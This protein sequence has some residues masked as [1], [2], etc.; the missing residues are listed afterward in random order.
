MSEPTGA[1]P[2]RS[3]G[4]RSDL[5]E[6]ERRNRT[7]VDLARD[8][9]RLNLS[10][11][12][13]GV[14]RCTRDVLGVELC[15]VLELLVDGES[16]LLRA[17]VGRDDDL[18]GQT[19]FG[20]ALEL[21]TGHA[22]ISRDPVVI[23]DARHRAHF[24]WTAPLRDHD[25]VSGVSTPIYANGNIF[26]IL[27][28]YS[29][30]RRCYT[31]VEVGFL[32]NVA[33]LLGMAIE[34]ALSE[35]SY[36]HALEKEKRR[37]DAAEQRYALLHEANVVLTTVPNGSAALVAVA[38]LAVPAL[39]DWCFVEL[40][41]EDGTPRATIRRLV[42]AH[43]RRG[44]AEERLARELSRH[45]PLDPNAPYGTPKVLRTGR[46]ELIPE[47]REELLQELSRDEYLRWMRDLAPGSYLCVPLQVG[48]RLVGSIGFISSAVDSVSRYGP[49]DL[50]LA[51]S[52]ARC[53]ALVV[54]NIL[55]RSLGPDHVWKSDRPASRHQEAISSPVPDREPGLTPRQLEVL[56]LLDTGMRVHQIKA[57][58]NLSEPTVRTHVRAILRAFG[59]CSQIEALHKARVMGFVDGTSRSAGSDRF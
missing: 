25:I 57:E 53:T 17:G 33:E 5:R 18:A 42:V 15:E 52:L 50:V 29:T 4:G 19:R 45:Y 23:E 36:R 58:L 9:R 46:P 10:E 38:R 31:E 16:V 13:R 47:V 55:E 35:S 20:T 49:E 27:G 48:P 37:A 12:M 8:L 43:S 30:F 54:A 39:A 14:A 40:V 1:G 32:Q 7:L 44:E 3:S 11:F 24:E 26:G 21:H 41:E 59:A 51:E 56:R 22:L 28:A 34:R 2:D 6:E